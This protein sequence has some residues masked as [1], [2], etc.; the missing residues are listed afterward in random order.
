M[1]L[2]MLKETGMLTLHH[3]LSTGLEKVRGGIMYLAGR[4]GG[5]VAKLAARALIAPDMASDVVNGMIDVK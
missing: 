4:A 1:S 2:G 3:E 5:R